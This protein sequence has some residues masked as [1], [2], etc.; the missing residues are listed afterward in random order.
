MTDCCRINFYIFKK[1]IIKTKGFYMRSI[2]SLLFRR[3]LFRISLFRIS[4]F[5]VILFFIAMMPSAFCMENGSGTWEKPVPGIVNTTEQPFSRAVD[6][7]ALLN[8]VTMNSEEAKKS[9]CST[10]VCAYGLCCGVVGGLIFLS[11]V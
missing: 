9:S 7:R 6:E 1:N 4:L 3:R 5:R 11:R 10:W 2:F 8:P